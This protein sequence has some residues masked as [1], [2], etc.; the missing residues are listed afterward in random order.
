MAALAVASAGWYTFPDPAAR[1]PFGTRPSES[2]PDLRFDLDCFL[3]LP[4]HVFVGH[5]DSQRDDG[6]NRSPR[7]DRQ[8]GATRVERAS[9][10]ASA[11]RDAA[12]LS[13]KPARIECCVLP[14][15]GHSFEQNV[16]ADGLDRRLFQAFFG[17]PRSC[18]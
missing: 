9:R 16:E 10:W 4:I 5:L 13:G 14:R 7:I 12:L 8:Q 15:G 17:S 3:A 18:R 11:L 6:L 2:L 1:F